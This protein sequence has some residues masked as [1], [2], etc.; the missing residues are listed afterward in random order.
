MSSRQSSIRAL[1]AALL[2]TLGLSA[3]AAVID[4]SA[5]A[6]T[7][8]LT[9]AAPPPDRAEHAPPPR[10]GYVWGAGHWEWNGR[11]YVWVSGTWIPERRA[12]HW[13][14][15]RWEQVGARWHYIPGHWER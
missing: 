1:R 4:Q 11:S 6:G 13:V 7:D 9:D 15:D 2:L 5:F 14:V 10:D 8:T 12:A 3:A